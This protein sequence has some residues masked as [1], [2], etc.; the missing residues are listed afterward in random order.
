VSNIISFPARPRLPRL[1]PGD[2]FSVGN[3]PEQ[4]EL[5]SILVYLE[6]VFLKAMR[7][8][9]KEQRKFLGLNDGDDHSSKS[10]TVTLANGHRYAITVEL[11]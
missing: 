7:S 3:T 1:P 11:V 10:L 2:W 4:L 6:D 5:E 8:R 9:P